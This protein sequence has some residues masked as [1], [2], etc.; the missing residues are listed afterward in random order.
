MTSLDAGCGKH[1]PIASIANHYKFK[2][3]GID[4]FKPYLEEAKGKGIYQ[5]II[6]GDVRRLPFK[7]DV[8]MLR[9]H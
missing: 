5:S 7:D 2:V 8:L 1:S 4:I 3:I 6:L 9:L